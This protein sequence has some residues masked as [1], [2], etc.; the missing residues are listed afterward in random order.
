M[1]AQLCENTCEYVPRRLAASEGLLP[2]VLEIHNPL[3]G[4]EAGHVLVQNAETL[5]MG[6][7][8]SSVWQV[9]QIR[10]DL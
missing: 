7:G 1:L 5:L 6:W 2:N 9:L 10:E 4:G 8:H 3:E